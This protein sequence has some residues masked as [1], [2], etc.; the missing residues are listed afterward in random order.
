[1]PLS[2][3]FVRV[4][5]LGNNIKKYR[6]KSNFTL[7][8]IED[9]CELTP[10]TLNKLERD[11]QQSFSMKSL[12]CIAE[13]LNVTRDDLFEGTPTI[14]YERCLAIDNVRYLEN[15]QPELFFELVV[16]D[17]LLTIGSSMEVEWC[18]VKCDSNWFSS[19][20]SRVS[21]YSDCRKCTGRTMNIKK[22]IVNT[23]PNIH[24]E[25]LNA[26]PEQNAALGPLSRKIVEFKCSKGHKW[27]DS[28]YRRI[29]VKKAK[30][31][32]R[33]SAKVT[34]ELTPSRIDANIIQNSDI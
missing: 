6:L 17:T 15:E 11:E 9:K 26:D 28:V 1:M 12:D 18:C 19:V 13:L 4:S 30:Y 14:L 27:K 23:H 22:K 2:K 33:C 16:P 25:I 21:G 20:N 8:F 7:S 3:K 10:H 34:D 32:P 29:N 31:C 5:L 24:A